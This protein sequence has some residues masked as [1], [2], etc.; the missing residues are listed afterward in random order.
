MGTVGRNQ[1][2]RQ[3]LDE[4][5]RNEKMCRKTEDA[6]ETLGQDDNHAG[7]CQ[8]SCHSDQVRLQRE[9]EQ[10]YCGICQA[11]V[12]KCVCKEPRPLWHKD[13]AQYVVLFHRLLFILLFIIQWDLQPAF[14]RQ[15]M[16]K[17]CLY[18]PFTRVYCQI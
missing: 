9:P 17:Q 14:V 5:R 7:G 16:F 18:V 15:N 8:K 4:T 10:P 11:Y 1:P 3:E 12:E 6:G 13:A 2:H